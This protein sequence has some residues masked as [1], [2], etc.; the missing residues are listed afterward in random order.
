M[1][2]KSEVSLRTSVAW[3]AGLLVLIGLFVA[4]PLLLLWKR[5]AEIHAL[6]A[7]IDGKENALES[8]AHTPAYLASLEEMRT[9]LERW[10][11][12]VENESARL[13]EIASLAR[14]NGVTLAGIQTLQE[15]VSS[16]SR[17]VSSCHRVSLRGRYDQLA[18]FCDALYATRGLAGIDK[19]VIEPHAQGE[20]DLL[21]ASVQVAWYGPGPELLAEVASPLEAR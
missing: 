16:D 7:D 21:D 17:I 12:V 20:S 5:Q 2:A 19:L 14:S 10:S 11:S 6:Q 18:G 1:S 13:R 15:N 8:H 9:S 3:C 4:A